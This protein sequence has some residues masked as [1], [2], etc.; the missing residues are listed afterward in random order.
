MEENN[1]YNYKTVNT[2]ITLAG[3]AACIVSGF[4]PTTEGL[5]GDGSISIMQALSTEGVILK[6]AVP[7]CLAVLTLLMVIEGRLKALTVMLALGAAALYGYMDVGFAMSGQNSIGTLVNAIGIILLLT[8][9]MLQCFATPLH[10]DKNGIID[11]ISE[12]KEDALT[13]ESLSSFYGAVSIPNEVVTRSAVTDDIIIRTKEEIKPDAENAIQISDEP[14]WETEDEL[15][16]LL[17]SKSQEA[18][19]NV[20][21]SVEPEKPKDLNGE[22]AE[23]FADINGLQ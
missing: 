6:I 12:K 15:Q 21:E 11:A 3:A 10:A 5:L 16:L 19:K 4:I 14:A 23:L 9:A 7:A 13:K 18:E 2:L 8:G 20:A 1:S 17:S 22:L